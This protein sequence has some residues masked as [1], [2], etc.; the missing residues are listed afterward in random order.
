[1]KKSH[2]LAVLAAA[3]GLTA[4]RDETHTATRRRPVP[5]RPMGRWGRLDGPL[6]RIELPQDAEPTI[7][8]ADGGDFSGGL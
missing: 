5:T 8:E 1:M 2:T 3:F 4:P 7:R 6:A